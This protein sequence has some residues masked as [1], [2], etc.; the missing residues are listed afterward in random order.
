MSNDQKLHSFMQKY[1]EQEEVA[2][3]YLVANDWVLDQA[4]MRYEADRAN[5][6]TNDKDTVARSQKSV[7]TSQ[8]QQEPQPASESSEDQ[9]SQ[10]RG[11]LSTPTMITAGSDHSLP[12]WGRGERLGS[13]R[14]ILPL[15][16]L[17][18][19]EDMDTESESE[20]TV[21][22]LHL[23]SEGFTLDEGTLQLYDVPANERL[24]RAMMRGEFP[25][26]MLQQMGQRI[27]LSV[28]DHTN[29]SYY[30]LSRKRFMGSGRPLGNPTPM[31]SDDT[32]QS[33]P[34]VSMEM[35]AERALLLNAQAEITTIQFRLANGNRIAGRFNPTHCVADLYRYLR[36]VRPQTTGENFTLITAFPRQQLHEN[37]R[38]T[39]AEVNLLNV[40]VIQH[41]NEEA[42]LTTETESESETKSSE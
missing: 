37:D 32:E 12:A 40:V 19:E 10:K 20:H 21:V 14:A 4:G 33:M 27:E 16:A 25:D 5:K 38:R 6:Q 7:H 31:N 39:L 24:L 36:T 9:L 13:A 41:L 34:P 15:P 3:Q 22:V 11:R 29:E 2:R 42:H 28:Q 30:E 17:N 26:N 23:W 8:S 18:P 1:G 35:N